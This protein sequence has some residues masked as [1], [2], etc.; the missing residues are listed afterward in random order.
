MSRRMSAIKRKR[1]IVKKIVVRASL[2]DDS[3]KC[4]TAPSAFVTWVWVVVCHSDNWR[5][6]GIG[7]YGAHPSTHT[8]THAHTSAEHTRN[9][10]IQCHATASC[11]T[12]NV[13]PFCNPF[14][15]LLFLTLSAL[16]YGTL[17]RFLGRLNFWNFTGDLTVRVDTTSAWL[18]QLFMSLSQIGCQQNFMQ[19]YV[20]LKSLKE[21]RK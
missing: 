5:V 3:N 21:V 11:N 18:G 8:H 15:L 9:F 19:R 10:F 7:P 2:R 16:S 20:S 14:S 12:Y 1:K 17:H 13:H 4:L 6:L